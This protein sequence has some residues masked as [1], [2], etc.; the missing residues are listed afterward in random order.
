MCVNVLVHTGGK[1]TIIGARMYFSKSVTKVGLEM[2]Q[3]LRALATL[4]ED[5][6]WVL[7]IYLVAL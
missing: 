5:L 3:Q 2:A 6:R 4:P 7:S 1:V